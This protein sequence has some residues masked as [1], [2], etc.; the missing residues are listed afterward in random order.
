MRRVV[1]ADL[2]P[3]DLSALHL[4]LTRLVEVDPPRL[5]LR[6]RRLEQVRSELPRP[7][8]NHLRHPRPKEAA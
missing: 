4:G 1:P 7:R 3:A 6:L 8:T 5:P 2:E